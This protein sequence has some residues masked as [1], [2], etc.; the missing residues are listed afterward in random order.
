MRNRIFLVILMILLLTACGS[1][2]TLTVGVEEQ[3][4]PFAYVEHN[5]AQG[6]DI[7]LW[8]AIAKEAGFRYEFKPMG[9]GEMLKAIEKEKI[10][11]AL[12]GITM[13]GDR[14]KLFDF[15]TPYFDTGLNMLTRANNKD[16]N[17]VKDLK[18]KI[19]ATKIG[20]SGYDY[21]KNLKDIK[22]IKAFPDI[23][24]AYKALINNQVDVVI[25]DKANIEN[26]TRT[27]GSGKVK[28][29]GNTLTNEQYGIVVKKGS[30]HSGRI[31]NALRELSDNGEYK[32]IYVKWF[33]EKPSS[34]PGK[35]S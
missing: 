24:S 8:K 19:I 3:F 11:V 35:K 23:N 9:Q 33:G 26:Y 31:N 6:F 1:K 30:R 10:D 14:K 15:S 2:R 20:S 12:A 29:V 16:I 18:D 32:K 27:D 28:M 7:E 25:F 17:A 5:R 13:K 21:A 34:L 22:E 4:K